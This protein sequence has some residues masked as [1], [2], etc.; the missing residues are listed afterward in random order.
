MDGSLEQL[1]S[2][3][4]SALSRDELLDHLAAVHAVISRF[5]PS[6]NVTW[7]RWPTGTTI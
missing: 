4:V 3:D 5:A 6:W 7:P 1:L 2:T